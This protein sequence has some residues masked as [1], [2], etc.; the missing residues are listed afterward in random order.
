MNAERCLL[1]RQ[2]ALLPDAIRRERVTEDEVRAAG[3]GT[4]HDARDGVAAVILE[5]DGS[6]SVVGSEGGTSRRA[7]C[8]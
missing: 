2:G 6:M 8:T 3:R 4:G 1:L 7:S 5:T